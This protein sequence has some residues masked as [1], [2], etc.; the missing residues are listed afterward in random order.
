M[1]KKFN[2][3]KLTSTREMSLV[4]I[5]IVLCVF[6][7]MRNHSFL[8]FTNINDMITNA[9]MMS[10]LS[11]GMM[12]VLLIGGIDISIGSTIAFSGMA[13]A[14]L[15]RTYPGIPTFISFI[16]GI[17]VGTC[18]GLLIGVII[19]KG[20]VI[21][22]I[23]TMGL[24]NAFRGA[25]YLIA[26]NQWVAAYQLPNGLKSFATGKL[27]GV[28]NMIIVAIVIYIIFTYFIKYTRTGR[29]I[30]AVGSNVEA[31]KV[32]GINID[33]INI[34]VYSLMGALSG[35]VGVLWISKYASAQ[36]DAATGFEIDIIAACVIGGVSLNGGKGTVFGVLLGTITLGILNNALPL[37]NIS[38]FWQDAIKG[39]VIIVAIIIN[40]LSQRSIDKKNLKRRE[41]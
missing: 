11:V 10:I 6:I 40:T 35:L 19:A 28:N 7:Q 27:L 20:R 8:S 34:L 33:K 12:C 2:L 41:L 22:I 21:P 36:G 15:L 31:A 29:M 37:I 17:M 5:L 25:T 23:A 18:C 30:Y 16:L 26:N 32:S 14:L 24:M 13:V 3:K 4:I 38:P 39:L 1:E 9:T